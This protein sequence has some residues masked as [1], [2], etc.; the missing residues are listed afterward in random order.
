LESELG[1]F[2][3]L[4][5]HRRIVLLTDGYS[6]PFLAKTAIS[7]LRYAGHR[8]AAVLDS[9]VAAKDAEAL[10]GTGAGVPVVDRL[11]AVADCDAVYIG[12]APPGGRLPAA[13][14][15]LLVAAAERGIDVVSGLHEFLIEHE[16]LV[17]AAER[18]GAALIDVR[19]N[20]CRT[21]AS[22]QPFPAESFRLLTVGHD[23]SVGKMTTT[24][25]VQR[26]LV[27]GGED[28]VF[29]AT[30]QTGIMVSGDGVPVDCVVADFVNGAV[31]GLVRRYS[32]HAFVCV[33]GQGSIS[34]PAFSAVTAG[35]LHGAAPQGLIFCYEAGRTHVKGL[36]QVPIAALEQQLAAIEQLGRLRTDCRTIGVAVNTRNLSPDEADREIEAAE[37]RFGLP[38]CDVFRHGPEKLY[39][40]VL[41]ARA[42][43]QGD[44]GD[45]RCK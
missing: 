31:E 7:L 6:T 11:E 28:A 5:E 17:V 15:P 12:I 8:V 1:N 26:A 18:G 42:Q 10:F 44:R 27:A 45:H 14:W 9:V 32:G 40:A 29:V 43:L 41:R 3:R 33:E 36:D 39:R 21:T 37:E 25:E 24:L 30:G 19:R 13:W 34:H 4:A 35:L 23:C 22:G 2:E 38:A 16:A 20:R